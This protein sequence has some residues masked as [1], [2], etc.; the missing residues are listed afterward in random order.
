MR[1]ENIEQHRER[2]DEL[3]A[4]STKIMDAAKAKSRD[5]TP[6]ELEKIKANS[7]EFD[8]LVAMIRVCDQE[9]ELSRPLGR[10]TEP[11][12]AAGML[13]SVRPRSSMRRPR[14]GRDLGGDARKALASFGEVL[15]GSRPLASMS[16]GSDPDGGAMVPGQIDNR[17]LDQLIDI[18]PIRRIAEVVQTT[19]S[20]YTKIVNK[21]GAA[22]SWGNEATTRTETDTPILAEIKPP[23][24]ELWA[25][26]TI[27]SWL[28]DDATFNVEQFIN[29]NVATEFAFQEGSA[30][31]TGDGVNKPRGFTTYDTVTTS[32]ATRDFGTLQHVAAASSTVVTADE[33]INLVYALAPAYRQ[34]PGVGWV[35]NST[36]ASEIR[37]LTDDN[38]RFLWTDGLQPG[39]PPNL[40]G[41]P[42]TEAQDMPDTASGNLA[43]AFGNWPRCYVVTDRLGTKM[44]RDDITTPG[45]IKFSFGKRVG[46]AVTDS[47]ALKFLK[48]N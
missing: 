25:Y 6:N 17:I 48:M 41:F 18:S 11:D 3:H 5:L 2:Q 39:Q 20:D 28:L 31:V 34:G 8:G 23:S 14:S 10:L 36:T 47:N 45:R 42:V 43:I 12:D 13:A 35:F 44:I 7:A 15:R 29:E 27:T 38:A 4:D 1:T 32:D 33:L 37:K 16:V 40:L 19:S 21:R 30:F 22:S 9:A 46:G 24:G 26:P